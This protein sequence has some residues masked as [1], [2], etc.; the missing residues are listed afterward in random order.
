MTRASLLIAASAFA[1]VS[2][3]SANAANYATPDAAAAAL[4][5]AVAKNNEHAIEAVL[6]PGSHKL[7]RSG[8]PVADKN[9]RATFTDSYSAKHSIETSGDQATLIIGADDFPFPVPLEHDVNGWHFDA[10]AGAREI[11]A[12]RIGHDELTAI[13]VCRAVVDAERDYA[14]EFAQY[15]EKFVSDPGKKNGLYWPASA[16]GPESPLGP[17]VTTARAQGYG[18]H[19]T[20]YHGYYFKL[21][22]SQGPHAPDGARSYVVDGRMI[23]GFAVIAYPATWGNSGVMSFIVNQDGK[24]LER[25]LGRDTKSIAAALTSYDPDPDWKPVQ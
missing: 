1:F 18:G 11:L 24:V 13:E 22:L 6:G 16:G 17:M 25:N 9:G 7:V 4:A 21:L 15:A 23:G 2:A 19:H 14:A 10:K 20:P 5:A 12:R 3:A 8:D